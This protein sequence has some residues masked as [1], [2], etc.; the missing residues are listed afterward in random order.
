MSSYIAEWKTSV[1]RTTDIL[2]NGLNKLRTYRHFKTNY[3]VET[4]CQLF[5]TLSYRFVFAQFRCGVAP[6]KPE[7]C[8]YEG[9]DVDDRICPFCR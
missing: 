1:N 6:L 8:R 9:I 3:E 4:Y 7:T 2:S 5:L